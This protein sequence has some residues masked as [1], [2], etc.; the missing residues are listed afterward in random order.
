ML[1]ALTSP[2]MFSLP[3][4]TMLHNFFQS[5][6]Q[7]VISLRTVA[8]LGIKREV[9]TVCILCLAILLADLYYYANA[10]ESCL[11]FCA[12]FRCLSIAL[13]SFLAVEVLTG[14]RVLA[15]LIA[16]VADMPFLP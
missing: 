11:S 5:K 10:C 8:F 1:C 3:D 14:S 7:Q 2:L 4:T 12:S 6:H 15:K 16:S 9:P 13:F